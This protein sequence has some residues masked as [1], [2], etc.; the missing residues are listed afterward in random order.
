[1]AKI[2][3]T[4]LLSLITLN[5]LSGQELVRY[6]TKQGLPS[7]HVYDIAQ[8]TAGFMWFATNRGVVKYDGVSFKTFTVKDGLPNNDT[9]KLE[10]DFQ[11]RIWYFSKSNYQG[12]IQNDSIYKFMVPEG[13]VISPI[14]ISKSKDRIWMYDSAKYSYLSI[15]DGALKKVIDKDHRGL[16]NFIRKH[17]GINEKER[18]DFYSIINPELKQYVI[19]I[20]NELFVLD[21]NFDILYQKKHDLL[22]RINPNKNIY[23]SIL[24]QSYYLTTKEG[25]L[26][27]NQ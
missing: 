5:L 9:W 15:E 27:I 23:G 17:M 8:D 21:F 18:L 13:R 16:D 12:Y 10:A 24:N 1:M 19:I 22:D 20:K 2:C 4:I 6:T 3:F 7:N 26:F 11:G 14:Q 25:L